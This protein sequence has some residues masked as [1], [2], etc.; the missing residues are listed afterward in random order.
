MRP[1][2]NLKGDRMDEK[3]EVKSE[4]VGKPRKKHQDKMGPVAEG[5]G[6]TRRKRSDEGKKSD[7][8]VDRMKEK[9]GGEWRGDRKDR[10]SADGDEQSTDILF[11][12]SGRQRC[13]FPKSGDGATE[14]CHATKGARR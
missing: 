3:M 6:M 1:R 5:R 7:E 9:E 10:R 13:D 11:C 4:G 12:A 14:L 2:T 8:H